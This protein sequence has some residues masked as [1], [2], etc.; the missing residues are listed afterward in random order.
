MGKSRGGFIAFSGE[1]KTKWGLGLGKKCWSVVRMGIQKGQRGGPDH[2]KGG[3][4]GLSGET[5][6]YRH[7][8][9]GRH[10]VLFK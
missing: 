7:C 10:K 2:L 5:T 8:V 9:S 3:H 1:N 6:H 4:V